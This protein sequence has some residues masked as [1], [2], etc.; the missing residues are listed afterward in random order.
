MMVIAT[1]IICAALVLI[2]LVPLYRRQEWKTFFVYSFI[3]VIILVLAVLSDY[4][5]VIPS[6]SKL[7]KDIVSFIFG[8]KR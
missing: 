7:T 8:Q 5:I 6:P 4:N 3:I 1:V 2:D